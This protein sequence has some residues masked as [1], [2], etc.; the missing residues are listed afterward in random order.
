MIPSNIK[1]GGRVYDVVFPYVFTER[2]DRG[3][4]I[5][6]NQCRILISELDYMGGKKAKAAILSTFIH[7]IL[8]GLN[9]NAGCT[10]FSSNL[11]EEEEQINTLAEGILALLV[12]NDWI[13]IDE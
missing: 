9:Y 11:E 3:G 12:D 4:Q 7:E 10:I 5:D 13:K 8:H 1:I 6:Y 2:F